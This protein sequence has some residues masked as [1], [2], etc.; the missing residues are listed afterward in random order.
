MIEIIDGHNKP[1][2]LLLFGKFSFNL[3]L[4]ENFFTQMLPFND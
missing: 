2:P 3:N 4:V 1:N